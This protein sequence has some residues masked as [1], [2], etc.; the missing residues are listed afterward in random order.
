VSAS[1]HDDG[2]VTAAVPCSTALDD[3]LR[4]LAQRN[5]SDLHLKPMRPPLM[6]INGLLEP[7]DAEALEPAAINAMLQ[8]IIPER[9]RHRL[10]E[11]MS[12]DFGYGVAG[13]S[14]F[15]ASIFHQRG[16]RA[17]VFRRVPFDFPSL[18]DW[19][20]PPILDALCDL[21][22]GLVLVTGP[23]GSGK[24]STLA[25]MLKR[26]VATRQCHVITIEDPIEFLI[27][28]DV[29]TVSQR[30]IGID[31]PDFSSALR[32]LL[33]Q[34]PDVIMVGEMRDEETIRTVITAAETGHF[35][36]STLHTNSAVQT[37]D[38]IVASFPQSNHVQLRQQLAA[39]LEAVISLQLVP[40][41]DGSGMV[42]A[43][44]ILRRTPQISKLILHGDLQALYEAMESSVVYHKMQ[45]MN[46]S[47]AALMLHGT[48]SRETALKASTTPIELDLLMRKIFGAASEGARE[49][50][51]EMAEVTSDFSKI[52]ELQE[53]KKLYDDLQAR[54]KD[55]VLSRDQEV[56][57]LRA[58]VAQLQGRTEEQERIAEMQ[59]QNEKLTRLVEATRKEYESKIERLNLRLRELSQ[60]PA[61]P[62]PDPAKR[63]GFFKR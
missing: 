22:Q 28:D 34:D 12:I 19:G 7:I 15:R 18:E 25:S 58:E 40:R 49:E 21:P 61:A 36:L 10:V 55:D 3:L 42:A 11:M 20:M 6:R 37:I 38:R 44:E 45:S 43:A 29:G 17:A 30:E 26:I 39:N 62:A 2:E 32:G 56:N 4:L 48:I 51:S 16:T 14:R 9:L 31:T 41:Q 60:Q 59:A 50:E 13:V 5:A 27:S 8:P 33:R 54:Y 47:L 53:V 24:S 63:G 46:Q 35:V 57:A 23:T 1:F 52:V